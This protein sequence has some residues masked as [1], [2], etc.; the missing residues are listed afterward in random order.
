MA[1]NKTPVKAGETDIV[2]ARREAA[3]KLHPLFEEARDE[4]G[5]RTRGLFHIYG[6]PE[7]GKEYPKESPWSD[8]E[9]LEFVK[10]LRANPHARTLVTVAAARGNPDFPADLVSEFLAGD[11]RSPVEKKWFAEVYLGGLAQIFKETGVGL[12]PPPNQPGIDLARAA[13]GVISYLS[14]DE[15]KKLGIAEEVARRQ[16]ATDLFSIANEQP[17][18]LSP[19]QR[20]YRWAEAEMQE[21]A[22][23]A[24]ERRAKRGPTQHEDLAGNLPASEPETPKPAPAPT[25]PTIPDLSA[26]MGGG[27]AKPPAP[28]KVPAGKKAA[29]PV[30]PTAPPPV[31]EAK[32]AASATDEENR[33]LMLAAIQK[34]AKESPDPVTRTAAAAF[35]LL[36]GEKATPDEMANFVISRGLL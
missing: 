1:N 26:L 33:K 10:K 22:K 9:N 27:E 15:K 29:A 6:I 34:V 35:L 28:P 3:A 2:A 25:G 12:I 23:Q 19:V 13:W 31:E 8:P 7:E 24:A 20:L 30:T 11:E 18:A 4:N 16:L 14:E 32:P 36:K 5:N 17:V 21:R